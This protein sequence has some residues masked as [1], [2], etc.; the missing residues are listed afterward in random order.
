MQY[1]DKNIFAQI[2]RKELSAEVEYENENALV[3][4]DKYPDAP[5]HKLVLCK[6]EYKD[7]REFCNK[8]NTKEKLDF[9]DAIQNELNKFEGGAKIIINIE[10]DGGQVVFHLHAH[11]LGGLKKLD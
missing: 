5:I 6:G 1:D 3:I 2:L 9:L 4:K 7:F 10:K 11:I 8:A